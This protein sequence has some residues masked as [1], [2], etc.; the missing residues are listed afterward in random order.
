MEKSD[1]G[2]VRWWSGEGGGVGEG[3]KARKEIVT[4]EEMKAGR[5]RQD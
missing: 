3:A 5:K 1:E 4:N 2:G